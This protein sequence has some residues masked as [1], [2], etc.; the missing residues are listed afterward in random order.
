MVN[1]TFIQL[2]Q[3]ILMAELFNEIVPA[4][5]TNGRLAYDD[6]H[7]EGRNFSIVYSMLKGQQFI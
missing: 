6:D 4:R 3:W 7:G 5:E 2:I 1:I